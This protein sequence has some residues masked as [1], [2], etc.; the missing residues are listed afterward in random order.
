MI[1]ETAA[2]LSELFQ[3]PELRQSA[4]GV[5]IPPCPYIPFVCL[6]HSGMLC[7]IYCNSVPLTISTHNWVAG[8][9]EGDRWSV[10]SKFCGT[11]HLPSLLGWSISKSLVAWTSKHPAQL[12]N[13]GV[14]VWGMMEM[15]QLAQIRQEVLAECFSLLCFCQLWAGGE[16]PTWS[17][18]CKIAEGGFPVGRQHSWCLA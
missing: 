6:L 5:G 16:K 11:C 13:C 18:G 4:S 8:G 17:K 9:I 1:K 14:H 7:F 2:A 10:S 12:G 15:K 3:K